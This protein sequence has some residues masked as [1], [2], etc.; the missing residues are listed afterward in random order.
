MSDSNCLNEKQRK[1][2]EE[3]HNLIYKFL[4]TKGLKNIIKK[5]QN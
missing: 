4:A 1:F 5:L 3:N 2:A